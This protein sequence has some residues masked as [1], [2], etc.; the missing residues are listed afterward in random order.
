MEKRLAKVIET[1]VV[2]PLTPD[3]ILKEMVRNTAM[4]VAV[5]DASQRND[6]KERMLVK[7]KLAEEEF[8]KYRRYA[9]AFGLLTVITFFSCYS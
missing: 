7:K 2:P 1:G 4:A 3:E 9:S 6:I 5:I 8:R